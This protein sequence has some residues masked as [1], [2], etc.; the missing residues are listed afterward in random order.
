[1]VTLFHVTIDSATGAETLAGLITQRFHWNLKDDLFKDNRVK[2]D[3][4]ILIVPE[5]EIFDG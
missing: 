5:T 4:V 3:Y 1:V 2:F